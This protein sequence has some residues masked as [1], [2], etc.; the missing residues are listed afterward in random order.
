MNFKHEKEQYVIDIMIK[1]GKLPCK[2]SFNINSDLISLFN[3]IYLKKF[4][5]KNLLYGKDVSPTKVRYGE[6]LAGLSLLRLLKSRSIEQSVNKRK[7]NT[8]SGFIYIISNP[9]FMNFYKIGITQNMENRLKVYQ[10]YDPLRRYKIEHYK[11]VED[12]RQKEKE[13]L[14]IFSL[15]ISKG[16]WITITDLKL[17]QDVFF[18]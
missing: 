14:E 3:K 7:A 15:N 18:E 12:A 5:D 10:T 8:Q 2:G 13:F 17:L 6:K 11:F 16:E 4:V 1:H 9:A